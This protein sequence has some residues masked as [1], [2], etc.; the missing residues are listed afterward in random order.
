MSAST[1][2]GT[3]ASGLLQVCAY[4][5]PGITYYA[6]RPDWA[7]LGLQISHGICKE[8][9]AEVTNSF[10]SGKPNPLARLL[11]VPLQVAQAGAPLAYP[12][13]KA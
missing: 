1:I 6:V 7:L 3:L 13:G 9:K 10:R 12:K 5:Y 11:K 4:C 8:C 2:P